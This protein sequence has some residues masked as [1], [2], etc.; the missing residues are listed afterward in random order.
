M[1]FLITFNSSFFSYNWFLVVL[2]LEVNQFSCFNILRCVYTTSHPAKSVEWLG[3]A[4]WCLM[5]RLDDLSRPHFKRLFQS[6]ANVYYFLAMI[7]FTPPS[8]PSQSQDPRIRNIVSSRVLRLLWVNSQKCL[9]KTQYHEFEGSA[10][11]TMRGGGV[12]GSLG[13]KNL[14]Q[15]NWTDVFN[16]FG[17]DLHRQISP[18]AIAGHSNSQYCAFEGPAIAMGKFSKMF[19][20]D[21]ISRIRGSCDDCEEGESL[22]T[23]IAAEKIKPTFSIFSAAV[24]FFSVADF[25]RPI[26]PHRN[27]KTLEFAILCLR[28]TFNFKFSKMLDED[29]ILR[30]Q[31]SCNCDWEE[32]GRREWWK[33]RLK[34]SRLWSWP[35]FLWCLPTFTR[36]GWQRRSV[37]F[38][39]IKLL[40]LSSTPGFLS[41][42]AKPLHRF[43]RATCRVDA[44][45]YYMKHDNLSSP[46]APLWGEID[47]CTQWVY[48]RKL[49]SEQLLLQDFLHIIGI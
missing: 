1:E 46:P 9:T 25:C 13:D 31:G 10:P 44:A 43:G 16:F 34:K 4:T 35:A 38:D 19:D 49:N 8:L 47:L 32:W 23:K 20:E 22:V 21:S 24:R 17:H 2:S 30:I 7:F 6:P 3:W 18:H 15:K 29:T 48:C 11:I 41:R 33:L 42:S 39:M 26:S 14:S 27:C 45:L 36:T 40:G 28:P 12:H 37:S 5:T